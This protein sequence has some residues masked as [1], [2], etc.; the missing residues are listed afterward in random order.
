MDYLVSKL[1]PAFCQMHVERERE[2]G[3]R[4]VLCNILSTPLQANPDLE[5]KNSMLNSNP[6][7]Y[8]L[9]KDLVVGGLITADEFWANRLHG[10]RIHLFDSTPCSIVPLVR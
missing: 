3:R 9:Y 6:T 7:L 2:P 10:V 1:R 5:A 8:Q 4:Q